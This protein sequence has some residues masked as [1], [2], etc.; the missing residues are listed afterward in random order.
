MIIYMVIIGVHIAILMLF[1]VRMG[2]ICCYDISWALPLRPDHLPSQ[3]MDKI[4]ETTRL[5]QTFTGV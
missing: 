4:F 1:M 2:H 3:K 5:D